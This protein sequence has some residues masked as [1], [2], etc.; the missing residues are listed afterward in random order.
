MAQ[1]CAVELGEGTSSED[2]KRGE[3]PESGG[4]LS[5]SVVYKYVRE[6]QLKAM[7][8]T[9]LSDEQKGTDVCARRRL[10]GPRGTP[11]L[12]KSHRSQ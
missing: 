3:R 2:S 4:E 9:W 12:G 7:H 10:Q 6:D 5:G 1:M 8:G 11:T